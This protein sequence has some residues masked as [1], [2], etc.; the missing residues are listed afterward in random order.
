MQR[1]NVTSKGVRAGTPLG[2]EKKKLARIASVLTGLQF[3]RR[4]RFQNVS[5]G[6]IVLHKEGEGS[7]IEYWF[8]D[9]DYGVLMG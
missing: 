4:K 5:K 3:Q 6:L 7:I 2:I 1:E 8:P 9:L